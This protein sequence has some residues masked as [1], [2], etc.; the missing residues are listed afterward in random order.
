MKYMLLIHND[1]ELHPQPGDPA[2]NELM[3]G[4]AAFS[5]SLVKRGSAFAGE[6]LQPPMTA[7]T[8]RVRDRKTILSDG[9]FAETKEWMS[10]YYQ[11]ECA[12][13]DEALGLAAQIPSAAFG[14]VEVRPLMDMAAH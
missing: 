8:V 1:P 9:P 10:G 6:P 2:W 7:T 3:A 5:E 14:S 12:N 4:Y 13:L 11:V